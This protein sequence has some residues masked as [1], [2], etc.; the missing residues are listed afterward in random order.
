MPRVHVEIESLEDQ[1]Q[2]PTDEN[3]YRDGY[4]VRAKAQ[5]HDPEVFK[6]NLRLLAN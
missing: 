2:P 4:E 6:R 5:Q 1:W 3:L